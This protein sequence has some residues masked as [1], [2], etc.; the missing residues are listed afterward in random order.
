MYDLFTVMCELSLSNMYYIS[1]FRALP[2]NV[3]GA[4]DC[5][6]HQNSLEISLWSEYN[7]FDMNALELYANSWCYVWTNMCCCFSASPEK[8]WTNID[9]K[10]A[11]WHQF[12]CWLDI[13]PHYDAGATSVVSIA[14][15][16]LFTSEILFLSLIFDHPPDWLDAG[17]AMLEWKLGLFQHHPDTCVTT[18]APAS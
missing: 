6:S 13:N 14:G 17:D 2:L 1:F 9:N 15:K 10:H 16:Y 18:L 11:H 5:G 8:H 3:V 7:I 4:G 12:W